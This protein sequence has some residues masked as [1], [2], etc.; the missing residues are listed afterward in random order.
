M[1]ALSLAVTIYAYHESRNGTMVL[2]RPVCR[3]IVVKSDGYLSLIKAPCTDN[4]SLRTVIFSDGQRG[5]I[6]GVTEDRLL[7]V[8]SWHPHA[9][10]EFLYADNARPSN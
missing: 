8:K 5:R 4:L 7:L 2:D 6:E 3:G 9:V 1:H 10:Q